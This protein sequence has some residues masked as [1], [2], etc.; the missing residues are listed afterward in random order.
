M[1]ESIRRRGVIADFG[2]L[3]RYR[4]YVIKGADACALKVA[5]TRISAITEMDHA[6]L[7][8]RR[9]ELTDWKLDLAWVDAA[10]AK[11]A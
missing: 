2:S 1:L 9:A 5:E 10:L 3:A 4:E 7:A 8:G 6:N 11:E